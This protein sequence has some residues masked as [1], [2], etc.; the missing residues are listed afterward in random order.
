MAGARQTAAAALLKDGTVLVAGGE[1]GRLGNPLDST[2]RYDPAGDR[3]TAAGPM[4]DARRQH[5][6]T[7]LDNGR[8]LVVGGNAG[9]FGA[10]L[11]GDER[12]STVTTTL[13]APDLGSQAVG[14]PSAVVDSVLA[15]TGSTAL[16][17]TGASVA[18]AN[19]GDFAIA[20]DSC[21]AA[22]VAP[23]ATCRVGLRFTPAA[24][25]ARSAT[26]AVDDNTAP[27]TTTASLTGTG[28]S[29]VPAPGPSGDP[30]ATG[31]GPAT[32]PVDG[33]PGTGGG[34]PPSPSG[35]T[36]ANGAV[37]P[38]GPGGGTGGNGGAGQAAAG[39]GSR[40]KG[41]RG[42][43]A[44]ATCKARTM[45]RHGRRRWT[46]SCRVTWPTRH[47]TALRAR[48]VHRRSVLARTRTT[49]RAGR[50]ALRLRPA[51]PLRHGR[52]TVV[53]TRR[54]GTPVLRRT[55]RVS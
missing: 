27:G 29:P 53:I 49:A 43:A 14:T 23:G 35:G 20:S 3:W 47:A 9:G 15:N 51:R 12:F 1:D 2:E 55:I 19:A 5:T 30:G 40:P 34:V 7:A 33:T 36:G 48:L 38:A 21:L 16:V 52:Y 18:G 8:A 28:L 45:R 50:A 41:G 37:V 26:L 24:A 54:D 10:G 42:P 4:A 11:A 17:V 6:L 39:A 31:G 25:G 44:R 22:P 46:V 13:T 32:G